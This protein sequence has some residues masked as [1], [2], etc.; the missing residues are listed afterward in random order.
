MGHYSPVA[1]RLDDSVR[2]TFTGPLHGATIHA[3]A[4]EAEGEGA[5]LAVRFLAVSVDVG[6]QGSGRAAA[7]VKADP[8]LWRLCAAAAPLLG[9]GGSGPPSCMALGGGLPAALPAVALVRGGVSGVP[10]DRAVGWE[11]EAWLEATT[12]AGEAA[13]AAAVD[14]QRRVVGLASIM[15]T[16]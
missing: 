4:E 15:V 6:L 10:V 9:T 8:G 12:A 7:A 2:L 5:L 11:L 16:A 1:Q 3:A 13:A 14:P